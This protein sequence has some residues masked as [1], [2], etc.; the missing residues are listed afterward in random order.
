M[1]RGKRIVFALCI[2]FKLV[3]FLR[4]I[5]YYRMLTGGFAP[6]GRLYSAGMT[7]SRY[8]LA[9]EMVSASHSPMW[10]RRYSLYAP[11]NFK[12]ALSTKG[13]ASS[14]M[15]LHRQE[16]TNDLRSC[17]WLKD[18]SATFVFLFM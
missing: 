3:Y 10:G 13:D 5:I 17:Q 16:E 11:S 18:L 12:R 9:S 2:A 8:T 6:V 1:N 7:L 14:P 4:A 15:A